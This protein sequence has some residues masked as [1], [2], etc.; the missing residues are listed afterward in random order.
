MYTVPSTIIATIS[1]RAN[2]CEK[3][4]LLS[5][6]L[7]FHSKYL[8]KYFV[9]FYFFFPLTN[10]YCLLVANTTS[11]HIWLTDKLLTLISV[12]LFQ[13]KFCIQF[14][15]NK[16][17]RV[18]FIIQLNCAYAFETITL[19]SCSVHVINVCPLMRV[20]YRISL[21]LCHSYYPFQGWPKIQ[22][23]INQS[24][25]NVSS[26]L[27]VKYCEQ[28]TYYF[29]PQLPIHFIVNNLIAL[30]KS[31]WKIKLTFCLKSLFVFHERI[32]YWLYKIFLN[33]LYIMHLIWLN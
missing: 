30:N 23:K 19:C 10:D 12:W 33:D 20:F 9:C 11:T 27:Q 2:G 18:H 4:S 24:Y 21:R 14:N 5:F 3:M 29:Q 6:L 26:Y 13:Q 17:K 32:S 8:Q 15:S 7:V 1:I 16:L 28:A 31:K 22:F 25:R